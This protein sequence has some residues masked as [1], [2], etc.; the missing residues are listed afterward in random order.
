M[1]GKIKYILLVFGLILVSGC[2]NMVTPT[3]GAKDTTPPK[4][5]KAEPENHS[6]NFTGNKIEITFDEYITLENASQH[7]L[8]SPPLGE[9]PDIKL[10]NKTVVIKFKQAL[11]PNTTY[12]INFGSAVKDFHEGNIFKDYVYSFS[13]GE[14]IDTLSIAG[15]IVDAESKKAIEDLFV[16]LYSYDHDSL[17][18][19]PTKYP[20]DFI[21]KTDKEGKFS[22]NGLPDKQFLVFALND[23]NS[24]LYYDL[25][26]ETV[27]FLDTLVPASYRQQSNKVLD[28]L[29]KATDSISPDTLMPAF[30]TLT[31]R[32]FNQKA[33]DLNLFAF[34]E[35]DT[36][37]MLLEKKLVEEGLLRFVFRQPAQ[38]VNFKFPEVANDTFKTVEVW[39]P[40]HDTLSYYFT[41][42][43]IDSLRVYI[44][45]DTLI[46]DSTRYSL[47]Y[48]ETR[49]KTRNKPK[50]LK[51]SN[52][53]KNN[54]LMPD[55][56]FILTFSEPVNNVVE[57]DTMKF[58]KDDEYGLKYRLVLPTAD[59]VNYSVNI[60]D[61]VFYSVRGYT[62]DSLHFNF[63]KATEK[64]IGNIFIVVVPPE[65]TQLVIQLLN[66]R[67]GVVDTCIID[68]EHRV[69]FRGLIPEKYKI[70]AIIDKDRS[71]NWS[72]GNFHQRFLPETVVDYKDE[73]DLKAGWDID[74]KEKWILFSK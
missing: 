69:E 39:S 18:E 35:K 21:T 53:L 55:E 30:D 10:N 48:R 29:A 19:R 33:L 58:E 61:S 37:Q 73:L 51:V 36:T 42:N 16:G 7:V 28:T 74:L 4:V 72:T 25:P 24:N 63:K 27:A 46:N 44:Q 13:T 50:R 41:P 68:Q 26:N 60:P 1:I 67:N 9:K 64:D 71:G 20:P 22:L 65:N 5:L 23:M 40:T 70:N 59:T 17:F 52:N 38:E 15:K 3:G 32:H 66:S 43:V 57:Y 49:T 31:T 6:I 45:Y 8:F 56:A 2:A 62:N 34:T 12:T 54:L 14:T 47:R 11:L